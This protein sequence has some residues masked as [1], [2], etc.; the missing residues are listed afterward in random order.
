[1]IELIITSVVMSLVCLGIDES[2]QTGM[3][4]GALRKWSDGKFKQLEEIKKQKINRTAKILLPEHIE[5]YNRM[6]VKINGEKMPAKYYFLKPTLSCF[7]CFAS[8]WGAITY[9]ATQPLH[10]LPYFYVLLAIPV[11]A[12]FN[13][14]IDRL[15]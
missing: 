14:L 10:Q 5:D 3:I 15:R 4:F 6:V 2:M 13:V 12:I 8:F 7:I 11:T 1:V 9:F